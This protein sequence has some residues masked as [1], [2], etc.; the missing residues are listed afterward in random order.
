VIGY[1]KTYGTAVEKDQIRAIRD[2]TT[3]MMHEVESYLRH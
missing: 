3:G 2:A 1:L